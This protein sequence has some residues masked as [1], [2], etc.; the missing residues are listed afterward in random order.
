MCKEGLANVL[1]KTFFVL[2]GSGYQGKNGYVPDTIIL[3]KASK[4][5]RSPMNKKL[6]MQN[7]LNIELLLNT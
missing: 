2:A 1:P 4:I 5:I 3:F 7:L 6:S